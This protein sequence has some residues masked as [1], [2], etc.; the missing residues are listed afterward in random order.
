MQQIYRRTSIPKCDFNKVALA[1]FKKLD[2]GWP[3]SYFS[4]SNRMFLKSSMSVKKL[5][6]NK[7]NND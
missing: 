6:L 7:E 1:C 4:V 5:N 3:G 2:H